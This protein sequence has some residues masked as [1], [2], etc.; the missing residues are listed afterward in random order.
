MTNLTADDLWDLII[1]NDQELAALA[2]DDF[3]RRFQLGKRGDEL[4]TEL[5]HL[6]ADALAE[7]SA[8]WAEDAARKNEHAELTPEEKASQMNTFMDGGVN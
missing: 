7:A 5:R 3:A 4:R 2:T 8:E 6:Q 1:E